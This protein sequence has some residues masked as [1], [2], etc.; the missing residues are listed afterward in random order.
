MSVLGRRSF[1]LGLSLTGCSRC[2]RSSAAGAA[3]A[4]GPSATVLPT[5]VPD[6]PPI[7]D[8]G[9]GTRGQVKTATWT[10]GSDGRAVTIA[11]AWTSPDE[12]LPLLFALHGR[13]E[14]VKGPDLGVMGWPK[15]YA[16][17]RAIERVCAPPL[18]TNDFESFVEPRR[19]EQHNV[20][21]TKRQFA[22]VVIVCPYSPDVDLR[23]PAQIREYAEYLTKIVMP[24]AKKELPVLDAPASTGID[25]V[26]LGG[27]LSLRIGLGNPDLFGAIGTLQP[28]IGEDQVGELVNLAS[29][30]RARNP[31]LYLRLV[32][33]KDDYF[34]RAIKA[35]SQ[36]WTGAGIRHDFEDLPGP[37]DYPFNRGPGAI[38]LLLWHD[39]LLARA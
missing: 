33:S 38:E 39:R 9:V 11:P 37:H 7:P 2:E 18:T 25:G 13:G 34:K 6:E 26:S 3:G 19:L 1:L 8:S 5:V 30:A 35:T 14:A 31:Q 17:L 12:R 36:A 21:L 24:R 10:L 23:K 20:A 27:A 4:P 32:T 15:D 22:G 28:A 29:A 16:L